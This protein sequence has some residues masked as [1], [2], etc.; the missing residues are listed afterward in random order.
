MYAEK[1]TLTTFDV[2]RRWNKFDNIPYVAGGKKLLSFLYLGDK[3]QSL[4]HFSPYFES[5]M[6]VS[7]FNEATQLID[8]LFRVEMPDTIFIDLPLN[9]AEM[10]QFC[11]FLK[12]KSYGSKPV[13]IY[14]EKRL[15]ATKINFLQKNHLVDDVISIHSEGINFY[16]KVQFLKKVKTNQNGLSVS[17]PALRDK[18]LAEKHNSIVKRVMDI[19]LASLIIVMLLPFLLIIAIAIMIESRGPVIYTSDRAGRGFKIFKFYKFRTMEVGADTRI[20]ELCHL[21][22]YQST[23]GGPV[24]MKISN[25]PRVTRVGKILRKTSLDE[26]PQLINVLKGDMSLVGNRPLP[27]YEAANLTTNECVERFMAPAGITG[28]WQVMKRGKDNMSAEERISLDISYARKSNV[29]YDFW[30]MARTSTALFQ[31]TNV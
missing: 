21:N 17:R 9:R 25:D 1:S 11:A 15:D 2:G 7:D 22:Q 23:E 20:N 24:F 8:S 19:V 14:N 13:V 12:S 28:L 4:K 26:I 29:A 3:D 27:L 10:V 30:I 18:N 6:F 5:G 16:N 31:K